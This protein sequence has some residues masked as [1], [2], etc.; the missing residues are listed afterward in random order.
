MLVDEG[1]VA[2]EASTP[3]GEL[4]S[5][6]IKGDWDLTS[7]S[8]EPISSADQDSADEVCPK[9]QARN[10]LGGFITLEC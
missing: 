2:V 8:I 10:M 3:V 1:R 5:E 4:S 7:D 9:P 6:S